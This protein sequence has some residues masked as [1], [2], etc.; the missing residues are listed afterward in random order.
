MPMA[1]S[2]TSL[3][4]HG[5]TADLLLLRE[6]RPDPYNAAGVI[7]RVALGLVTYSIVP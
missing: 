5:T 2:Y 3:I 7:T 6:T 4:W 1:G